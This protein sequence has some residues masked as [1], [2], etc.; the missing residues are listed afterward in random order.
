MELNLLNE[1]FMKTEIRETFTNAASIYK[2][3]M[4]IIEEINQELEKENLHPDVHKQILDSL[5]RGL[6]YDKKRDIFLSTF[7]HYFVNSKI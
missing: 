1:N 6:C 5:I 3:A 7:S 2:R 4:S